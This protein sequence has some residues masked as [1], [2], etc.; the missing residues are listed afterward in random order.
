MIMTNQRVVNAEADR[1]V[2]EPATSP[3]PALECHMECSTVLYSVHAVVR[4]RLLEDERRATVLRTQNH[5]LQY[6]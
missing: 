2:N 1:S 4:L 6:H 5:R 3:P